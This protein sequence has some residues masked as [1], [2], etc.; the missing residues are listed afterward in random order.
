M[1]ITVEK[2]VVEFVP[3]ND[4]ETAQLQILWNTIVDCVKFNRKL[5]PIGEYVPQKTN[6]ARFA[7]EGE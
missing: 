5:V 4:Q 7:V 3:D 1:K 6:L 2:N